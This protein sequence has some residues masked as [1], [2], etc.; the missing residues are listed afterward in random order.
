[1]ERVCRQ[2]SSATPHLQRDAGEVHDVGAVQ[3]V[4][5]LL[6]QLSQM[7]CGALQ[8]LLQQQAAATGPGIGRTSCGNGPHWHAAAVITATILPTWRC[9][10]RRFSD[11]SPPGM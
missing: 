9:S 5:G 11:D 8:L 1:M 10:K 4:D 7:L 2:A 6:S 3:L